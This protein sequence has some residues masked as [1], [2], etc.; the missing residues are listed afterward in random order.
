MAAGKRA[1]IERRLVSLMD[2]L[3]KVEQVEERFGVDSDY[4]SETVLMWNQVYQRNG[5]SY[6][7]TAIKLVGRW[8]TSSQFDT[9][10]DWD[11]LVEKYLSK[12]SD[13]WIDKCRC[14]SV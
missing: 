10:L 8:Y 11:T 7:F 4:P 3:A 2:E 14:G 9:V 12:A 6:T 5:K 1:Y 13:V